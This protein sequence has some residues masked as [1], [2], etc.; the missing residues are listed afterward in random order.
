MFNWA[1]SYRDI[2]ISL[3][4]GVARSLSMAASLKSES[5]LNY[6]GP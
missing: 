4:A 2:S 5:N 6:H 3:C 1:S